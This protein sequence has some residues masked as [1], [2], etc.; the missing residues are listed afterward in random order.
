M[1]TIYAFRRY[2]NGLKSYKTLIKVLS[3]YVQL[4]V[5]SLVFLYL[6]K[7]LELDYFNN[8][9]GLETDNFNGYL[10]WLESSNYLGGVSNFPNLVSYSVNFPNG[11]RWINN[12]DAFYLIPK[13]FG[14]IITTFTNSVFASNL[15]IYLGFVVSYICLYNL[16]KLYSNNHGLNHTVTLAITFSPYFLIKAENHPNY[17]HFWWIP[18][19]L[20]LFK[21]YK[22]KGNKW[23]YSIFIISVSTYIDPYFILISIF[24]ISYIV[25]QIV[26]TSLNKFMDLIKIVAIYLV[27][28][29]PAVFLYFFL[30]TG[31]KTDV[32]RSLDDVRGFSVVPTDF[33]KVYSPQNIIQVKANILKFNS[34]GTNMETSLFSGV[35]LIT[36]LIF[37]LFITFR[38]LSQRILFFSSLEYRSV[39]FISFIVFISMLVYD[40][41]LFR[42]LEIKSLNYYL[43]ELF[44]QFRVYARLYIFF[45]ILI[46]LVIVMQ[47]SKLFMKKTV[48]I[49]LFCLALLEITA[50]GTYQLN[51]LAMNS[52]SFYNYFQSS[53][54]RN[55]IFILDDSKNETFYG[56]IAA[57]KQNLINYNRFVNFNN[58]IGVLD[59]E[60]S[61]LYRFIETDY[62]LVKNTLLPQNRDLGYAG[63]GIVDDT[64]NDE[65]VL[66]KVKSS[67][68]SRYISNY[69]SGFWPVEVNTH[70]GAWTKLP[71][72]TISIEEMGE[73]PIQKIKSEFLIFSLVKQNV[74]LETS[75]DKILLSVDENPTIVKLELSE[76]ESIVLTHDK[77]VSPSE[78]NGSTDKREL[79]VFVTR[80]STNTCY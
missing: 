13:I 63:F 73:G 32:Q 61:C 9:I 49:F 29:L 35:L 62:I 1:K 20:Y 48:S 70:S 66:Y 21:I 33:F 14:L 53:N 8:F 55:S 2:R 54:S 45:I 76:G 41:T 50:L 72:S 39:V 12:L 5:P 44:P 28:N 60:A 74:R 15:F 51:Y 24:V 18:L 37:A 17:V 52:K 36:L 57:H 4:I 10:W 56:W 31:N 22:S 71:Q 78:I 75:K 46:G 7:E 79:G 25:L 68:E 43:Y 16:F 80:P 26:L 58:P 27:C 11:I 65:F 67:Q 47:F 77:F 38:H 42:V 30:G 23:L 3:P 40:F 6:T 19:S 64:R 34:L 69:Q 59:P